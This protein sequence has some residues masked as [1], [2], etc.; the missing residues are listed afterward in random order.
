MWGEK[1]DGG[2]DGRGKKE[3]ERERESRDGPIPE[4]M[5]QNMIV[6]QSQALT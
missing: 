5:F 1:K 2:V 6:P 3:R 4:T